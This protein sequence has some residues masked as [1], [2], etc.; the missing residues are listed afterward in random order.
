MKEKFMAYLGKKFTLI[1]YSDDR[2]KSEALEYFESLT[3]ARK[4]K[5][6][7][8]FL[9]LG[10]S[11]KIFNKEKFC[12]EGDQIYALKPQPDRF[13]CFFFDGSKVIV[14]NAYEKKTKKIPPREKERALKAKENY[15]KRF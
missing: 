5:V 7:Q 1:W 13:L 14:T 6:A 11:G 15:E 9:L 12:Y 4:K 2:G 10:D 3:P 8:L